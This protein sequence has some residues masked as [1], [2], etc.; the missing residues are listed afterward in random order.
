VKDLVGKLVN[1]QNFAAEMTNM[2]NQSNLSISEL[3]RSN[4]EKESIIQC[5]KIELASKVGSGEDGESSG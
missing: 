1:L 4:E 2:L 3:S 5:Q